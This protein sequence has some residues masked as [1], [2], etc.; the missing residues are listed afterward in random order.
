[1]FDDLEHVARF[2]AYQQF[3]L[4]FIQKK[5]SV[6]TYFL[7]NNIWWEAKFIHTNIFWQNKE[8]MRKYINLKTGFIIS[9]NMF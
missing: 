3:F 8:N 5:I 4:L 6:A 2:D 7:R 9:A 1:M